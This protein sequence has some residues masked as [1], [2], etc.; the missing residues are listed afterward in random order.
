[1]K[2]FAFFLGFISDKDL[3]PRTKFYA[4]KFLVKFIYSEKATKFCE[5]FNLLV[6][7]YTV[8]KNKVKI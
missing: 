8:V 7:V 3:H 4:F 2:R 6:T 5:I 1:M